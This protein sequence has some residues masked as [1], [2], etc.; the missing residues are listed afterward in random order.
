MSAVTGLNYIGGRR[1]DEGE[2]L[3]HSVAADAVCQ[4]FMLAKV[5]GHGDKYVPR[6]FYVLGEI[7]G[8]RVSTRQEDKA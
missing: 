2:V 4:T 5:L 7:N 6:L 8:M 3:L 1:S